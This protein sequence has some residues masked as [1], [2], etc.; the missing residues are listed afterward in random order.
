[1]NHCPECGLK[2]RLVKNRDGKPEEWR[3]DV[4]GYDTPY[5]GICCNCGEIKPDV[6]NFVQIEKRAPEPGKG[7]GC[8]VCHV[9]A[10][11]AMAVLCDTCMEQV[12]DGAAIQYVCAGY[13]GENKRV[14]MSEVTERFG[15]D[16]RYH[17]EVKHHA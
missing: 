12:I 5:A 9:P 6:R 8:L 11:G 1:M 16:M 17:P 2:I 10:D 4:C 3:C 7:W 13:P 14:P 15:H